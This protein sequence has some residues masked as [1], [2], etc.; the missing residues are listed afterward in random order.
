MFVASAVRNDEVLFILPDGRQI[1]LCVVEIRS[2]KVFL[3][4]DA[5][6]DIQIHREAHIERV[7]IGGHVVRT[8]KH[9]DRSSDGQRHKIQADESDIQDLGR[10]VIDPL[11]VAEAYE[12][13]TAAEGVVP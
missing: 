9:L 1:V 2:S 13:L 3:G 8:V 4:F 12:E 6:S 7:V 10:R 5:P 11:G